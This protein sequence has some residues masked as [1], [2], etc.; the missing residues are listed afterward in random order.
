MSLNGNNPRQNLL[1]DGS[2]YHCFNIF[3][4]KNVKSGHQAEIFDF[5]KSYFDRWKDRRRDVQTDGWADRWTYRQ[6]D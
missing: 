2:S 3:W 5:P 4:S 1:Q 6:N